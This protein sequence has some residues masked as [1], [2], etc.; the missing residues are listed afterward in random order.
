MI[1]WRKD[2]KSSYFSRTIRAAPGSRF[3]FRLL[4]AAH[5]RQDRELDTYQKETESKWNRR[6]HLR[7]F[8]AVDGGSLFSRLDAILELHFAPRV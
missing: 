6:D 8:D 1:S 2:Q 4:Q 7:P 5:L 3:A